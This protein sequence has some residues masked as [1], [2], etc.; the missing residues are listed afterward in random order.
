VYEYSPN[1]DTWIQLGADLSGDS[2]ENDQFGFSVSIDHLGITAFVGAPSSVTSSA[3]YETVFGYDT[4]IWSEWD[5][6]VYNGV[7]LGE[8]IASNA[9]GTYFASGSQGYSD[10]TGYAIVLFDDSKSYYPSISVT[11][12]SDENLLQNR[13]RRQVYQNNRASTQAIIQVSSL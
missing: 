8:S 3:G 1:I 2:A 9:D 6:I 5:R 11:Q 12:V 7:N 4:G 13:L 10:F